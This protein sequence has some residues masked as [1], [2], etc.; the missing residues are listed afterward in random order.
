[1]PIPQ[2]LRI[3]PWRW[4][5]T[6]GLGLM[7]CATAGQ[8]QTIGLVV[9]DSARVE[10]A[11]GAKLTVPL[12][13]DFRSAGGL[14]LA[15]V[16]GRLTWASARLTLDSIR[17]ISGWTITSNQDSVA[18][19]RLVFSTFSTSVL[20]A[21]GP[22]ATAYFTAT[23]SSGGTR[24][25]FT[26]M[27]V[28]DEQGTDLLPRLQVRGQ[29][30]CV[31][32]FGIWGD[33]TDDAQVNVLDAQQVARSSVGLSVVRA[34]TLAARGD[35]SGDGAINIIDAQQIARYGVGLSAAVRINTTISAAPAVATLVAG[36]L[37]SATL[38][39]AGNTV[40]LTVD[41]RD[42]AANSVA[43]CPSIS[44]SSDNAAIATV[45]RNGLVTTNTPGTAIISATAGGQSTAIS[46]IVAPWA[47]AGAPI[48]AGW[49]H[50]CA[51]VASGKAYCWGANNEQQLG[52]NST[53]PQGQPIPVSSELAFVALTAGN[54][55]TCGL[56]TSRVVYCWGAGWNGRLGDG[57]TSHRGVPTR[58][59]SPLSFTRVSAGINH[60]CALSDA[61]AAY[62]WGQNASG[63][64]GD[65]TT[66][67]RS[68][69][70]LVLGGLAFVS[71]DAGRI[72]T[73]ATTAGGQAYCWGNNAAGYL[74]D[75]TQTNRLV[76]TPVAGGHQFVEI[77]V[78]N[79]HS[80]GRT[81]AGTALCWGGNAW[82]GT[83][84]SGGTTNSNVPV[85]VAGN[86]Q[87]RQL[88][89][90]NVHSCGVSTTNVLHCWGWSDDGQL[91]DQTRTMR[92]SPITVRSDI[93]Y[94]TTGEA[95]TCALLTNGN[96]EC[97]GFNFDGTLGR[98]FAR[99]MTPTVVPGIPALTSLTALQSNPGFCGIT[100][101]GQAH[102][103][104]RN[105]W[106]AFGA[107]TPFWTNDVPTTGP[108]NLAFRMQSGGGLHTCGITTGNQTYCW[109]ANWNGMVGNG[110]TNT[111]GT[112]TLVT[113]GLT[114]S[115][116]TA[117]VDHTCGLTTGGQAYCWGLGNDGRLGTGVTSGA[118]TTPTLVSGGLT[119]IDISSGNG[120]TCAVATGGAAYCW[121][122]NW[123]GQ[124]GN[125]TTTQ[126]D[127][128]VAVSG[129]YSFSRIESG[130]ALT[131]G[132][133]T[134]GRVACWG[135]GGNG[136]LGNGTNA[137]RTTPVLV[138]TTIAFAKLAVMAE[139]ACG[140]TAGGD[141][142]CWG[143]NH[144]GQLGTGSTVNAWT[145]VR[146]GTRS[147]TAVAGTLLTTCAIGTDT[148]T[149]CWGDNASGQAGQRQ[150]LAARPVLGGLT[151]RTP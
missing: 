38:R 40:L 135:S 108:Q 77:T 116:V 122:G 45:D 104:G 127:V 84:G 145:P 56:S 12:R 71:I 30:I 44:W 89:A 13:A 123:A 31:G 128:P 23:A 83:L 125:G 35:V 65:G 64:L 53:V 96:A 17:A 99:P 15:A 28:G 147:Y 24:I 16:Q 70:T 97:W 3:R 10:L 54:Q 103:W 34:T 11:P 49:Q 20:A 82:M 27:A 4:L 25:G 60:T 36:T 79:N 124:L 29:D 22:V 14:S 111:S 59:N 39:V 130:Y 80:C 63:Q 5:G 51:L 76:P 50:T 81:V 106:E 37:P 72:H 26:P 132:L 57:S 61:G 118:V 78:G 55:H 2:L 95:H 87:F 149:Y 139:R 52:I 114:F 98:G 21:S 115:K 138:S 113:G 94:V 92:T 90:G 148:Q 43:G 144:V 32:T 134:D 129:G 86:I 143:Q 48:T 58:I 1:M 74:G 75:G 18:F 137:N 140:L 19:G 73:C 109:G 102:C 69:P 85:P 100:A 41:P 136:Q 117:G 91:G 120:G 133:L 151:F 141:L 119:F 131:C 7:L 121:G 62:C 150:D 46:L 66:T 9:G 126:S 107:V 88:S 33:V 101:A 67:D 142:Y 68:S 112:P 8:A 42:A 110:T 47:L 6:S 93:A 105:L 146:I